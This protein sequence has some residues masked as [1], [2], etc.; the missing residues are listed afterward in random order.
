M[1]YDA[2]CIILDT[3]HCILYNI[4]ISL[5]NYIYNCTMYKY[6]YLVHCILCILSCT[7]YNMYLVSCNCTLY[8]YEFEIRFNT[9]E[10]GEGGHAIP[11]EYNMNLMWHSIITNITDC[12][13]THNNSPVNP[14]P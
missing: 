14:T 9:Y 6:M 10:G 2:L 4:P 7:M 5:S 3:V 1:I 8:R 12:L 13:E 11:M